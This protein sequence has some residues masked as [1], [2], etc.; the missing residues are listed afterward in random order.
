MSVWDKFAGMLTMNGE[1]ED[2]YYDSEEDMSYYDNT[3][4]PAYVKP[5]QPV[6]PAVVETKEEP[7]ERVVSK[8]TPIRSKRSTN[9][10]SNN[11]MEVCIVRP[12]SV[13][14]AREV[15]ERLLSERTVLLNLE[16][17]EM[18]IAQRIIDFTSGSCFAI[19]GNLQKVC[20]FIFIITP[21]SVDISGNVQG[22]IDGGGS[23]AVS[24]NGPSYI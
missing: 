21:P 2:D 20:K 18:D 13:E 16:G 17:I 9:N 14:E 22:L 4:E 3:P 8:P 23:D 11:S 6:K 7:Q 5:I 1:G 12:T 10:S 24:G 19:K 15:T